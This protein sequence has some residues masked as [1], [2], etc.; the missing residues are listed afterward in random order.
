MPH[1]ITPGNWEKGYGRP[2]K[3]LELEKLI[4][5]ISGG[6]SNI[7][8][9]NISKT[10]VVTSADLSG[11]GSLEEQIAEYVNSLN[12]DKTYDSDVFIEFIKVGV[13]QGFVF[14]DVGEDGLLTGDPGIQD[15]I[16]Y[17][18]DGDENVVTYTTTDVNGNYVFNSIPEGDYI[19]QVQASGYTPTSYNVGGNSS[20]NSSILVNG[21]SLVFTLEE[22][23][24][25][26]LN[27]GFVSSTGTGEL[28]GGGERPLSGR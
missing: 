11:N 17:L 3:Y 9:N 22:Q 24:T 10:I 13:I 8:Q 18:L 21:N 12:Y 1:Y 28:P 16:I 7:E 23:E 15:A 26:V 19:I 6:S 14:D 2:S 5:Q 27:A 4:R 20:L 25:V